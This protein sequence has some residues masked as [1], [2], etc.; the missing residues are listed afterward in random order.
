MQSYFESFYMKNVLYSSIL[1]EIIFLFVISH[2]Y[3]YFF[4]KSIVKSVTKHFR[5]Q[6]HKKMRY[7]PHLMKR[8]CRRK[9]DTDN[10]VVI[11]GNIIHCA[12][13]F[14]EF[15]DIVKTF[16]SIK[17]IAFKSQDANMVGFIKHS[18]AV[19]IISCL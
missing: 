17:G 18:I 11:S 8:M 12:I 13:L 3:S 6:I 4:T 7:L 10:T 2:I 16:I 1:F 5:K 14:N 19:G 15:F 9:T